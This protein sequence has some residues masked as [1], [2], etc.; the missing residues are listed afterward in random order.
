[1]G[2]KYLLLI[3]KLVLKIE[4]SCIYMD[5]PNSFILSLTYYN[6]KFLIK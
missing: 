3:I 2:V 1:M 6:D 4:V 5:L